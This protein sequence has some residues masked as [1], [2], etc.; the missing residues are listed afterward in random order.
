MRAL[1][2]SFRCGQARACRRPIENGSFGIPRIDGIRGIFTHDMLMR[3]STT[4]PSEEISRTERI[5]PSKPDAG[6]LLEHPPPH[7]GQ[8]HAPRERM[9]ESPETRGS[10]PPNYLDARR[11]EP[12]AYGI[13]ADFLQM[14]ARV[15]IPENDPRQ[16]CFFDGVA[17]RP[18]V[19][20]TLSRSDLADELVRRDAMLDK[21]YSHEFG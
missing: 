17:R 11:M 20:G 15:E 9:Q 7:V 1:S 5:A 3:S 16:I 13:E 18:S 2:R 10:F 19:S 4:Q 14:R 6:N 8:E 21:P 12:S